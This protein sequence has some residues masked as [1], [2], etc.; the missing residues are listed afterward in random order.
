MSA[1]AFLNPRAAPRDVA[2][3]AALV[4]GCNVWISPED[5]GWLK[6]NPSPYFLLPVLIGG[7]FGFVSGVSAGAVAVAM[8]LFGQ[9]W[10]GQ[11]LATEL[12]GSERHFFFCLMLAGGIC[13]ELQHWFEVRLRRF[14]EIQ[15]S[16]QQRI[17]T[18]DDELYFLREAKGESDR[19]V[20]TQDSGASTLDAEIRELYLATEG[21]FYQKFLS[22]LGRQA[23][24][25]DAAVYRLTPDRLLLRAASLGAE[26][27]LPPE[28]NLSQIEMALLAI[29][30][31]TAVSIAEFWKLGATRQEPY[32]LSIP[33]LDEED[34]PLAVL[35]VT[36]MPFFALN[37][38]G[39]HL[40]TVICKW[41]SKV[42]QAR[43]NAAG[44]F[45]LVDGVETQKIFTPAVLKRNIDLAGLSCQAHSLPSAVLFFRMPAMSPEAQPAFERAIIS[46]I[47]AGDCAAE[48]DTGY[49]NL[50]ILMP[51]TGQR[52]ASNR[53]HAAM[54][55][56]RRHTDL[57]LA[58]EHRLFTLDDPRKAETAWEDLQDYAKA[59]LGATV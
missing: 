8:I 14:G 35:L 36:G 20:A 58:V 10:T 27:N 48:L 11:R 46:S 34:D 18:L 22:L 40:I 23:H 2:L 1:V 37:Q 43:Q 24:V 33:L 5:W 12:L 45:R 47:R 42:T 31:K 51:L 4:G 38:K 49:P 39:V 6:T 50:A 28:L 52:V 17:K 21:E 19:I 57:F 15:E 59:T 3:L 29:E 41:A 7:R 9:C 25:S 55:Q 13:G 44:R 26:N 53:A 56:L 30:K 54:A 32:L 16:F